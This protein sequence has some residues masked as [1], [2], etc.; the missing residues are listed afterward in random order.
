M[1]TINTTDAVE[2]A[3]RSQYDRAAQLGAP[4]WEDCPEADRAVYRTAVRPH[5]EAAAPFIAARALQDA[6]TAFTTTRPA[7]AARRSLEYPAVE[8]QAMAYRHTEPRCSTPTAPA[9]PAPQAAD[10]SAGTGA[11]GRIH[12]ALDALRATRTAEAA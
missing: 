6:A 9:A 10:R 1:N 7:A 5:V 4:R 11:R 3:A 2:A 12:T 8:L